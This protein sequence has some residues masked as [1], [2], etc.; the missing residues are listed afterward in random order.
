LTLFIKSQIYL[1]IY[2]SLFCKEN[3]TSLLNYCR[4]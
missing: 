3:Q 4:R 2:F 1:Q